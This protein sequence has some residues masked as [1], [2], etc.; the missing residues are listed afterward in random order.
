MTERTC[1][2]RT[3]GLRRLVMI[4]GQV[5]GIQRM[6]EADRPCLDVLTQV[7]AVREA[8]RQVGLMML[9]T[10]METCVTAKVQEG[11][12]GVYDELVDVINRFN[13]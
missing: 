7:G 11:E 10:H 6:V 1:Q 12:Y 2:S 3:E 4:Q 5:R 13:R 9:R 8:L